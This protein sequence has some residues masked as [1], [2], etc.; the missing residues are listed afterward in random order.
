MPKAIILGAGMVGS[1]M[2]ADMALDP[3]FDVAVADA[4]PEALDRISNLVQKTGG[5]AGKVKT[6][7]ADLSDTRVLAQTIAPF[8][9]VLGALASTIGL[10]TLRTVIE[11]GKNFC[12]ICF[13]S[14]DYLQLDGLAKAKGVTAVVDCGVAPGMSNMIA[15]YAASVL[16]PCRNI[17]IYVGGLPVE[18]RWPYEYKAAFSPYDVIEEYT[19]PSRIVE[20]GQIVVRE[21]LSEPELMNLPHV[22]TV[23]AFNT[24]GL[25]SL[26][27]TLKAPFM[28]EKTLRYPG[29]IELMRVL[30]HTGL[31]GHE[32]IR[33]GARPGVEG[34]G[35]MVRPIDVISAL[36]FP[37]WT[38]EPGEAD[39]TVMRVI[40]DGM[41]QGAQTR[42]VYDLFDVLD[43]ATGFTSMSRTT[44]FPCTIMARLVASGK[45]K[46][47][48]VIPPEFV[49]QVP[50]MLEHFLKELAGRGVKYSA[51]A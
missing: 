38:Y 28:K 6:I 34:S 12:D 11:A 41:R 3:A 43:P 4:R 35:T 32:P 8:D 14:E 45:F 18:R 29:H 27:Y 24:D 1:V 49:G 37:K 20:N 9:I 26:A 42:L 10:Q 46:R 5:Q 36:M 50:G 48:G 22:G 31:F 17:E 7:R 23:E 13:M 44:A 40:A 2:A 30:R 19:R 51:I 21:A 47:P 15:G 25:R 33:V 39:L 16:E